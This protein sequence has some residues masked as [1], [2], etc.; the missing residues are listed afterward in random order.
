MSLKDE[1]K[2]T[3]L[4]HKIEID[5]RKFNVYSEHATDKFAYP[6]VLSL[7][8]SGQIFPEEFFEL[9]KLSPQELRSN[10][11]LFMDELLAPLFKENI[12]ALKMNIARAFIDVNRDK[13]E[14]DE[15]MY[16][17]YPADKIIFENS[18][19]RSGY[20][21][22]HRVTA[23]SKPI[24]KAPISYAEVLLRIKNVYDVYHKR[25]N[26]IIAK[27]TQKFGFCIVLDCHSMPSKICSIMDDNKKI[28]ICLG[29]LFAQSCPLQISDILLNNLQSKGYEVLKN[30]PYSGAY[31]TFNYCQPRKKIYTLQL[32][33]N[34]SLYANEQDLTKN[35]Q[36]EKIRSDLCSSIL[37]FA[38]S[39]LS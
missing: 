27:H 4:A 5:Y 35:Q 9:T 21:L 7:P 34:R 39:L 20:G 37:A 6:L 23:L 19:C 28:D 17:D 3:V 25:L 32:E 36:F 13:I 29:D 1:R 2:D 10:E 33:V 31:T 30:V 18:R 14:L 16:D 11:D 15:K 26:A 8:H 38:K 24:Y 22:I 12:A